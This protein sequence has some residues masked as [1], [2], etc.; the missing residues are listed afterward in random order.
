M[1]YLFVPS[2]IM[3]TVM[4]LLKTLSTGTIFLCICV[5]LTCQNVVL[6]GEYCLPVLSI[7]RPLQLRQLH[8]AQVTPVDGQ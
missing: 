4:E 5:P 8:L 3:F 6:H 2:E 7:E 1:S